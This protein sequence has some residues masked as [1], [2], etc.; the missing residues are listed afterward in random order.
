MSRGRKPA[1]YKVSNN[2]TDIFWNSLPTYIR[3]LNKYFI[4][5]ENGIAEIGNCIE[6]LSFSIPKGLNS[7]YINSSGV[8]PVISQSKE[9]IIGYSD[10]SDLLVDSD[11]P[12]IIFG[13][14]S[15][16]I[17]YVEK[18]FILGA[19]GVKLIKP[20]KIFNEKFFYYFLYG[21][22]TDTK[23][24]GRHYSLL[25]KGYIPLIKSMDLQ[26]SVV[27]F[28]DDLILNNLEIDVEYFNKEIE[29]IIFHYK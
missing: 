28:L 12:L 27:K 20:K 10:R 17:K 22:M 25:R 21:V 15:K 13:D 19:D 6:K 7:K 29:D 5:N 26:K 23:D 11:L 9:Y 1:S 16:T 14:H 3:I 18:P 8:Y 24:Y 2:W 4:D